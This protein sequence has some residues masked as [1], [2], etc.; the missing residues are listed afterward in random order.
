MNILDMKM[1]HDIVIKGSGKNS[2]AECFTCP[3]DYVNG[4]PGASKLIA[5][6]SR[7]HVNRQVRV[8]RS[9]Y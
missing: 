7:N 6:G 8:H 3:E 2:H 1:D 5:R 9:R 4:Y